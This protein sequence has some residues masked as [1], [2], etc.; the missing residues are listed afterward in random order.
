[1]ASPNPG[2]KERGVKEVAIDKRGGAINRHGLIL[3]D[4]SSGS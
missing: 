3:G 2:H 1:V 4:N